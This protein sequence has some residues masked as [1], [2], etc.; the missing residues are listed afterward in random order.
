MIKSAKIIVILGYSFSTADE[1]FNDLLRKQNRTAN[2]LV[3]NPSIEPVIEQVCRITDHDKTR[4]AAFKIDHLEGMQTG[5]LAFI[6]ARAEEI[7]GPQLIRL[8]KHF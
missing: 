2:L 7:K 6:K 1:H 5:R 4:L 8:L 3:I